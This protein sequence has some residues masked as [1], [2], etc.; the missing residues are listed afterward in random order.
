MKRLLTT[1]MVLVML[2]SMFCISPVVTAAATPE[3]EVTIV[4]RANDSISNPKDTVSA[5]LSNLADAT[6]VVWSVK[7]DSTGEYFYVDEK[8]GNKAEAEGFTFEVDPSEKPNFT[9]GNF[10]TEAKI[11]YQN[12]N[13]V[14]LSNSIVYRSYSDIQTK[15]RGM[16][17][18]PQVC[19]IVE[20]TDF[21]ALPRPNYYNSEVDDEILVALRNTYETELA[22]PGMEIEF[23]TFK[24]NLINEMLVAGLSSRNSATI[25]AILSEHYSA[26]GIA[27]NDIEKVWYD[28]S[29]TKNDV[30]SRL[31]VFTYGSVNDFVNQ[32]KTIA[33]LDRLAFEPLSNVMDFLETYANVY[34]NYG[35]GATHL[36]GGSTNLTLDF[37]AAGYDKNALTA[38]QKEYAA[39]FM[40]GSYADLDTLNAKFSQLLLNINSVQQPL[41]PTYTPPTSTG[42]S[43]PSVSIG[44][45]TPIVGGNSNPF[46][47]ID[48][49]EWAKEA[50]ITLAKEGVIEGV[51]SKSYQPNANVTREQFVKIIVNTFGL[52]GTGEV[53]AFEDVDQKDWYATYINT[54]VELGIIKGTSD[55]SFGVGHNIS[56]QDMALIMYR[57]AKYVGVDVAAKSGRTFTDTN[58]IDSYAIDAVSALYRAGII[59]GL[60]DG[61]FGGQQTATRAQAAKLCYDLRESK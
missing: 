32:F 5:K 6:W 19:T 33:F 44:L 20:A 55:S 30:A 53:A 57:V 49:V 47:D 61:V 38:D 40:A 13:I 28:A 54:A 23:E 26:L 60:A 52:K 45:G 35:T 18:D 56:R 10:T 24:V 1:V 41:P 17:A 29:S 12:G 11:S 48:G 25:S 51:S 46:T 42:P 8:R 43:G 7:A 16:L 2:A 27:I 36:N 21:F 58:S 4:Y 50:I 22:N 39:S 34:E 37:T 59:N 15:I 14:T 9:N 31:A 3:M